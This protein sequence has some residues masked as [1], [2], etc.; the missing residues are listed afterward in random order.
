MN[1]QNNYLQPPRAPSAPALEKFTQNIFSQNF[2]HNRIKFSSYKLSEFHTSK[3]SNL[4]LVQDLTIRI[5]NILFYIFRKDFGFSHF[6]SVKLQK[7]KTRC[8]Y[9]ENNLETL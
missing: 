9:L 5:L 3:L 2:T 6:A 8:A 7:W 4:Q 1:S